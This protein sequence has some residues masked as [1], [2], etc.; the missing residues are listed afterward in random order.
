[1]FAEKAIKLIK[2]LKREKNGLLQPYNVRITFTMNHKIILNNQVQAPL[3]RSRL[4][5]QVQALSP[6]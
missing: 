6:V 2:E 3:T 5:H 4:Y 1:M